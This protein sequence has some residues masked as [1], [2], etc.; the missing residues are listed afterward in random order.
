MGGGPRTP[1]RLL[2]LFVAGV[3]L[4]NAPLLAL[5]LSPMALFVVWAAL[6]GLLAWVLESGQ[7]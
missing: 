4:L 5:W 3:L 7:G 2:A 6:I 1:Q